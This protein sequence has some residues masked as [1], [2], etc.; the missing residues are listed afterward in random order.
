M[1]AWCGRTN[2]W[3]DR[4]KSQFCITHYPLSKGEHQRVKNP[5]SG[6]PTNDHC[7]TCCDILKSAFPTLLFYA[8]DGGATSQ[9]GPLAACPIT[10]WSD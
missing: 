7:P 2:V 3:S 6:F 4:S 9:Q 5:V 10:D 8:K 1:N